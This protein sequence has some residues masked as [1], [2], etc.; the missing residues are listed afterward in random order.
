MVGAICNVG[1]Q[2]SGGEGASSSKSGAKILG[3]YKECT[4]VNHVEKRAK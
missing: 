2:I 3:A 1:G 4:Y